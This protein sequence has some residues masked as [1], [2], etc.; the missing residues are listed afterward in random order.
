LNRRVKMDLF[1][2]CEKRYS[3]RGAY[4]DKPVPQEDLE[5]IVSAGLAAPSGCNAQTTTFVIVSDPGL[6]VEMRKIHSMKAVQDAKAIIACVTAKKP[7][8]V[9][10]DQNF[11]AEDCA[12]A[13][14]NMLLAI[15]A[16][17]YASVWIQ[18]HLSKEG[19]AEK[20]NALLGIPAERTVRVILPV[21]VPAG[22][23]ERRPKK[24][25]GARAWFNRHG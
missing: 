5:R 6:L 15:S 3:Y 18:G 12:A 9:Y 20:I 8:P 14:E 17:G 23:G 22:E 25:F 19:R 7:V 16:L 24:P 4:Q 13:I 1:E 2:A 10:E 21:G 11:E